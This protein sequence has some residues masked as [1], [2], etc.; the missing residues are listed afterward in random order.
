M[1]LGDAE[2]LVGVRKHAKGRNS[3]GGKE[4]SC[5]RIGSGEEKSAARKRKDRK[6]RELC[7]G[8]CSAG[9][10]RSKGVA[11][12]IPLWRGRKTTSRPEQ[13]S[14]VSAFRLREQE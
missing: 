4:T 3:D 8:L 12:L 13:C 2:I 5:P 10:S 6:R 14:P 1:P 11:C 7:S 9:Y